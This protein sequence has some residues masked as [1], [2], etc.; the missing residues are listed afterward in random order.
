M[1]DALIG[2]QYSLIHPVPIHTLES[3]LCIY[4][5]KLAPHKKGFEA[6]IGGPHSSFDILANLT[7]GAARMVAQFVQGLEKFRTGNWSPPRISSNPMTNSEVQVAKA[8]NALSDGK[9]FKEIFELEKEEEELQSCFE[10]IFDKFDDEPRQEETVTD[11][12]Q[13]PVQKCITCKM[14]VLADVWLPE[15]LLWIL[16]PDS[17]L[18]KRFKASEETGLSWILDCKLST[19]V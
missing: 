19:G 2:I 3:G 1:T 10:D 18:K 8:M 13:L 4:R 6:M 7:G 5:S 16:T 9:S 14:D 12:I 15:V 11:V 17:L